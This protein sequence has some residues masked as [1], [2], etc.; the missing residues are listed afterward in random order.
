MD[1]HKGFFAL[2][3]FDGYGHQGPVLKHGREMLALLK[4]ELVGE[5]DA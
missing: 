5:E 4:A 1:T 2:Q 3:L